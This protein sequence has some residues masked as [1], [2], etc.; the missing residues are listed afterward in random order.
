M[1]EIE[2]YYLRM[3]AQKVSCVL[4]PVE[5]AKRPQVNLRSIV[6][7]VAIEKPRHQNNGFWQQGL[8]HNRQNNPNFEVTG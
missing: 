7:W 3:V 5:A 2:W 4:L 1:D 6:Q 8:S